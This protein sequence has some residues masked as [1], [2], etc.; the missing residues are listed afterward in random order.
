MFSGIQKDHFHNHLFD[1]RKHF[2]DFGRLTVTLK[3]MLIC[4]RKRM[5]SQAIRVAVALFL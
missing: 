3:P 2:R 1:F 5:L 4:L